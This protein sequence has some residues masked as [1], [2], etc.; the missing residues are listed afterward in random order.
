[1]W[2]DGANAWGKSWTTSDPWFTL[3]YRD[4]AGLP[5]ANSG[6]FLSEGVLRDSAGVQFKWADPLDGNRG[7]LPE[8]IVPDPQTQIYLQHVQGIN[9]EY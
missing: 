4:S 1:M 6:R 5:A 7:G 9:P 2:G 3:A 8:V